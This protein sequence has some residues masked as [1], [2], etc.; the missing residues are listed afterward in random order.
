MGDDTPSLGELMRSMAALRDELRQ[1]RAELAS[2]H[3]L[4]TRA[5]LNRVAIRN[6]DT[7]V[8]ELDDALRWVTRLVVGAVVLGLLGIVMQTAGVT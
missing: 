3:R 2:I 6:L 1:A 7:R 4:E 8:D 5:E